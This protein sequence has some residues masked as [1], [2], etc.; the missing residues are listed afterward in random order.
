[1]IFAS[2]ELAARIESAECDLL[3]ASARAGSDGV[4]AGSPTVLPIGG[5]V[6]IY[7]ED[8]SPLN[9]VAGL[10][11]GGALDPADLEGVEA[12]YDRAG[13]PV[14]VE[15][16]TLA[17]PSIAPLLTARGY[18]IVGFE[19]VMGA[20]LPM[21]TEDVLEATDV[22]IESL[23]GGG[24]DFDEWL[25]VLVRGFGSPDEQ[26][27]PSHESFE[28]D[29]IRR[30]LRQQGLAAGMRR[31]LASR[32][33]EAAG[34]ASMRA[35]H[36]VA[37]LCGAATLPEH[38]RRGI[39]RALLDRRLADASAAGCDLA[40]V[41]T[42]PGSRSQKNVQVLGFELLYTRVVLLLVREDGE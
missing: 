18:R 14:Q 8:E 23:P 9:K 24:T 21:R 38:R 4:D 15:L 37:H 42:L 29:A 17:D 11:F 39:Q 10:G 36:G 41:T 19:N 40:V 16:S 13:V 22:A 35:A 26:G 6:A 12:M 1:M 2:T 7:V 25:S 5:G 30:V 27:V 32:A 34:G 31:Y 20:A 3:L 33:G 28:D